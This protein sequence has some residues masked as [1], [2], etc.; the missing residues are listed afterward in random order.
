MDTLLLA[1]WRELALFAGVGFLLFGLDDLLVDLIWLSF[2]PK[3]RTLDRKAKRPSDGDATYSYGIAIFVPAWDESAVIG[4]MINCCTQHWAGQ[5]YRIY[6][7]AYANDPE[8]IMAVQGHV[9]DQVRLVVNPRHGPTTKADCLNAIWAQF[10]RDT[11]ESPRPWGIVL[12]DAEDVVHKQELRLYRALLPRH[13]MVQVPVLPLPDPRSPWVAGHYIDEFSDAHGKE[14][15]VRTLI[16]ASLPSA[17]VGCAIRADTLSTLAQKSN[18]KPF[19]EGTLTEDYELGLRLSGMEQTGHFARFRDP[20]NGSLIAVRAYFP[21]RLVTSVRQKTRWIIGIALAGWDRTGWTQ[22]PA[23]IWMRWRDRRTILSAIVL[24]TGYLSLIAALPLL[25]RNTMPVP[26]GPLSF[27]FACNLL[28]LCWRL[29]MRAAMVKREYGWVQ[30]AHAV[31]R[32]LVSSI[33]AIMASRR[34]FAQYLRMLKTG[35]L[36][37]DKTR[38]EFPDQGAR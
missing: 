8:T 10:K 3:D 22:K 35:S 21:N 32:A 38:H 25:Y 7:G 27:L 12:H 30:A 37:W 6:I 5:E 16:G 23:E 14:L 18:A 19:D 9:N 1:L 29:T 2:G 13:S 11:Q 20:E 33:L 15:I 28:L 17:G 4:A 36:H 34:A 24:L 31:P 26:D